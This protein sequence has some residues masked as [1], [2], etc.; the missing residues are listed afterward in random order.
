MVEVIFLETNVNWKPFSLNDDRYFNLH[1][2][3]SGID[4]INLFYGHEYNYP[5]VTR[6][7]K[8]NGIDCFV[9]EQQGKLRD[10]GNVISIGLDTQTVFYQPSEFYTGQNVQI[11]ESPY[12]TESVAMFLIPLIKKQ[13]RV[14]N[15]GG[16]GATLS[17]LRAKNIL[18][19]T[20]ENE[21]PNW[22]Y[23]ETLFDSEL[24]TI[25][26]IEKKSFPH[27]PDMSLE[28]VSWDS[29][30][31]SELFKTA[32]GKSGPKGKLKH[33]TIPLISARKANNGFDDFVSVEDNK[34]VKN[35][36]SV[37]NNGDGGAGRAFYH[38][39][40]Y[41][42]TQDITNLIEQTELTN[43]EKMFISVCI[44]HQEKKFGFGNKINSQRLMHQKI[45]LPITSNGD[46]N[47]QFM[48]DYILEIINI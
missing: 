36:I 46:I 33:G 42:A 27:K 19:P 10:N 40:K 5:Y 26:A 38:D 15:W 44:S 39:Y 22:D 29:F 14:L 31:L 28:S 41:A 6:T 48:N 12:M 21:S 20:D 47:Y 3:S 43:A 34:T 1:S 37:V 35:S 4:K 32:R 18:L 25:D 2:T 9:S 16:N 24:K 11:L 13:L 8:N 45:M 23:I 7:D 17:R 30:Y